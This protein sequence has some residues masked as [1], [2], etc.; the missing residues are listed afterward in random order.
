[1]YFISWKTIPQAFSTVGKTFL[2][3]LDLCT[4]NIHHNRSSHLLATRHWFFSLALFCSL[5]LHFSSIPLSLCLPTPRSSLKAETSL[6]RNFFE[7][8][9]FQREKSLCKSI[10]SP[11]GTTPLACHGVSVWFQVGKW[12][13]FPE[14]PFLSPSWHLKLC[15]QGFMIS[16]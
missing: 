16:W 12:P 2:K 7:E 13:C 3:S 10:F 11:V 8:R 9:E 14:T 5:A 1:M 4:V 15:H 6:G